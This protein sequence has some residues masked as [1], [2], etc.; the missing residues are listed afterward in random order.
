MTTAQPPRPANARQHA[1]CP[2]CR[3]PLDGGPVLYW[4]SACGRGTYAADLVA[5]HEPLPAAR[6]DPAERWEAA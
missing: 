1:M 4:C 3:V 2:R 6:R 5:G